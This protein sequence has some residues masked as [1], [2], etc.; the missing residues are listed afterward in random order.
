MGDILAN[1]EYFSEFFQKLKYF[2]YVRI[3]LNMKNP[4]GAIEVPH[5]HPMPER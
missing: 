1:R 5:I 4:N 3:V 2:K